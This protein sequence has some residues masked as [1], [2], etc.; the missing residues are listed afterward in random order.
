MS[1]PGSAPEA[2]A[3]DNGSESEFPDTVFPAWAIRVEGR[4][5]A[6]Q[7]GTLLRQDGTTPRFEDL[8]SYAR[9]VGQLVGLFRGKV[10]CKNCAQRCACQMTR[11]WQVDWP[12]RCLTL[13]PAET[14][15]E[16][17]PFMV[18]A[19]EDA[20]TLTTYW[21]PENPDNEFVQMDFQP[22]DVDPLL[23]ELIFDGLESPGYH[24]LMAE[25]ASQGSGEENAERPQSANSSH[26]GSDEPGSPE[27][28][29]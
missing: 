20:D 25:C 5:W 23:R 2:P 18:E 29:S 21:E 16:S 13:R 19:G 24:W 27:S 15:T 4:A 22:H 9:E 10:S 3:S 6:V 12:T 11:R 26:A 1:S 7:S 14:Y 17:S 8:L 28:P